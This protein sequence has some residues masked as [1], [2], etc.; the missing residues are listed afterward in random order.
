MIIL[1]KLYC[2]LFQRKDDFGAKVGNF[3]HSQQYVTFT[4][5]FFVGNRWLRGQKS[6]ESKSLDDVVY[7]RRAE[8]DS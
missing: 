8:K 2:T 5:I 4:F 6:Q 1:I 3:G 7:R